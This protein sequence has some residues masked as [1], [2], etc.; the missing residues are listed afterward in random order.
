MFVEVPKVNVFEP[1]QHNI[2]LVIS[3]DYH[4]KYLLSFC[5]SNLNSRSLGSNA[6]TIIAVLVAINFLS[7]TA[8]FSQHH[9]LSTLDSSFLAY[10]YQLFTEGNQ[11]YESLDEEQINYCAPEILEHPKLGLIDNAE[12]GEEYQFNNFSDFLLELQMLSTTR[13]KLAFVLIFHP[14]KSLSLLINELGQSM[15]IDSHSHL[16]TGAIIATLSEIKLHCMVNYIQ[17]MI[18]RDWG[19]TVQPLFDVTTV[20]LKAC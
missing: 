4:Y 10:S 16:D 14:D 11:M 2:R 17:E 8:W 3:G 5:Q 9:L 7:D 20:K 15:L 12:R 18:L 1:K 19:N 6:C 13:I